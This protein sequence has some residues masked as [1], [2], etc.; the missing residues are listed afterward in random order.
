MVMKTHSPNDIG[1]GYLT[2]ILRPRTLFIALSMSLCAI[3]GIKAQDKAL[4]PSK[5]ACPVTANLFPEQEK[6]ADTIRFFFPEN[7]EEIPNARV[8]D[9]KT[10]A[11]RISITLT[12]SDGKDVEIAFKWKGSVYKTP[13]MDWGE[14][15]GSFMVKTDGSPNC[16][17]LGVAAGLP[18]NIPCVEFALTIPPGVDVK[19]VLFSNLGGEYV[20]RDCPMPE[21]EKQIREAYEDSR[22]TPQNEVKTNRFISLLEKAIPEYE[23]IP[24]GGG[25]P[26]PALF[27]VGSKAIYDWTSYLYQKVYEINDSAL[28]VFAGIFDICQGHLGEI[29]SDQIWEVLHDKPLFILKNWASIK[30]YKTTILESRWQQ[31]PNSN[32]EMVDIYRDIAVKEPRYKSAYDEIISILSE[33]EPTGVLAQEKIIRPEELAC[34]VTANLFPEQR[35]RTD[36]IR[37]IFPV[38]AIPRRVSIAL[39]NPDKLDVPIEFRW[40]GEGN[41]GVETGFFIV[42]GKG[43]TDCFFLSWRFTGIPVNVACKE[44]LLFI[45]ESVPVKEIN[46]S[47]LPSEQLQV[48]CP[49]PELEQEIDEA[50]KAWGL[51]PRDEN[52]SSLLIQLLEKITP[53]YDCRRSFDSEPVPAWWLANHESPRR[54][55]NFLHNRIL[56][57]DPNAL[58]VYM[59]FY[60]NSSGAYAEE[61]SEQLWALFKDRPLLILENWSVI[62][63]DPEWPLIYR[64]WPPEGG[65]GIDEMIYIYRD[66][67]VKEPKYKSACD[68]IIRILNEKSQAD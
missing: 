34:P 58:R 42:N 60:D 57:N 30:N 66:I 1:K 68:E 9:F 55:I 47:S 38:G 62:K 51:D 12:K 24:K 10:V 14:H 29:M 32:I 18:G 15:S 37:F 64:P 61:M 7:A 36:F 23:C 17:F 52:K 59:K 3:T 67:A 2:G 5:Y 28:R 50:Y 20:S 43:K 33:K 13:R 27:L 56:E 54:W 63:D 21:L 19:E 22:L 26:T 48:L 4:R 8:L 49:M 45:P 35:R 65:I 39:T 46:F 41:R 44:F 11:Q 53:R 25:N 31:S 16:Y 6:L 40:V